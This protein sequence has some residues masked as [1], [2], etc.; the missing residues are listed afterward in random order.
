MTEVISVT[1]TVLDTKTSDEKLSDQEYTEDIAPVN[2]RST[3]EARLLRKLDVRFLPTVF[4]IYL[5][6]YID[7]TAIATARLKGLE[8]DLGLSDIQ[9]DTAV[10]ILYASYCSAQIPSN[11]ILNRIKRPSLYIGCCVVAWGLTS[12]LTGIT[13]NYAGILSCRLFLG[14]PEAAFYPGAI[15]LLSR[16]YTRKELAFRAS[17]FYSGSLLSTAF[18]NLM[19][20]GILAN[21]EE[22]RGIRGWR[23][24]FFIEGALT[25]S[26]G[27]IA[28]WSLPDL[29]NNTRWIS[30]NERQLAQARLAEDTGEADED[31]AQDSMWE[32]L[33]M[34]VKDVRVLIFA[35]MEMSLLLGLSFV[36]FFPTLTATLGFDT[37]ITLLLAAPPWIWATVVCCLNSLHADKT[38]ERFWHLSLPWWGAIAGTIVA[39]STSSITGRYISLFLMASGFAGF[40]LILVWLSNTITRPPAKRAASIGLVNGVGNVG[41][42]IGSYTWKA[43]WGPQYHRSME[44]GVAALLFSVS[45]A[46]VMRFI[47]VRKNKRLD[48]DEIGGLKGA[49]QKRIED[50]ACLEGITMEEAM[51]R[52]KG[53]RYLY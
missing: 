7:R 1:R 44:I 32:G 10:A 52:K 12:A 51:E 17:L 53:F 2:E 48:E 29:P 36:N 33:K 3:T 21:L 40:T 18:G 38:G 16:W 35:L 37:T 5:M 20:A 26:V 49:N 50:A 8:E 47:L 24:L 15:Y 14:F 4:L 23:W 39:L 28:M 25:I 31:L 27:I 13:R 42:L 46:S 30:V 41:N 34:A 22:K 19:A 11:M 45:L 6:N 9:Y 43:K